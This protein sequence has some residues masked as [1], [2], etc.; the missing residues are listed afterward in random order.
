MNPLINLCFSL[1]DGSVGRREII[2]A[3]GALKEQ[4]FV[5]LEDLEFAENADKLLDAGDPAIPATNK[6]IE[7]ATYETMTENKK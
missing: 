1:C 7:K 3:L 4:G 6:L 5:N 2:C